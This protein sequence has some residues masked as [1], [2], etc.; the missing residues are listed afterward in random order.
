MQLLSLTRSPSRSEA[1]QLR[2]PELLSQ[3]RLLAQSTAIDIQTDW[4][5]LA[6]RS[7]TPEDN[8][9]ASCQSPSTP[10]VDGRGRH[11]YPSV[12]TSVVR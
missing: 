6:E 10:L 11:M 2:V 4:K 8:C 9:D 12:V 7:P 3:L 5:R 1:G